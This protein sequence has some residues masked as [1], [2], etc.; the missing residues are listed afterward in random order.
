MKTFGRERPHSSP[1]CGHRHFIGAKILGWDCIQA[2]SGLRGP[3][4]IGWSCRESWRSVQAPTVYAKVRC[5]PIA[6]PAE[7]RPDPAI[8]LSSHGRSRA[9]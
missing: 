1:L 7:I 6:Y 3:Q 9:L 8:R 2:R 5:T 4:P